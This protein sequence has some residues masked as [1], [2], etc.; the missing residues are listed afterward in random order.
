[1]SK[2]IINFHRSILD[3]NMA[4]Y[5]FCFNIYMFGF[6][7]VKDLNIFNKN[8]FKIFM[9][10]CETMAENDM[11]VSDIVF[12]KDV[13][14]KFSPYFL[15]TNIVNVVAGRY[16]GK[17]YSSLLDERGRQAD[18]NPFRNDTIV[19]LPTEAQLKQYMEDLGKV[20]TITYDFMQDSNTKATALYKYP[21][22]K[23]TRDKPLTFLENNNTTIH[24]IV[25]RSG[26]KVRGKR[27]Y[28]PI[29]AYID[30]AGFFESLEDTIN[31]L[32]GTL[33]SGSK[34][35]IT[36][37]PDNNPSGDYNS[38]FEREGVLHITAPSFLNENLSYRQFKA[39]TEYL[40]QK[41]IDIEFLGFPNRLTDPF[42][43]NRKDFTDLNIFNPDKKNIKT[44][45]AIDSYDRIYNSFIVCDFA[46]TDKKTSDYNVFT[47]I[48]VSY[49]EL[50][51]A[52]G[53]VIEV[54]PEFH[55]LDVETFKGSVQEKFEKALSNLYK[56][57]NH[58]LAPHRLC[59]DYDY[60]NELI[61]LKNS[62]GKS[63][64][65]P[66]LSAIYIPSNQQMAFTKVFIETMI[67]KI[68]RQ[69]D[70]DNCDKMA[71]EYRKDIGVRPVDTLNIAYIREIPNYVYKSITDLKLEQEEDTLRKYITVNGSKQDRA[72][73][74]ELYINENCYFSWIKEFDRDNDAMSERQLKDQL[75]SF[76]RDKNK[77][78]PHDDFID[79]FVTG[80]FIACTLHTQHFGGFDL[81]ENEIY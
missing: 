68:E 42:F 79:T 47:H 18:I 43:F 46:I 62:K 80:I 10:F 2:K 30:E 5:W 59:Y 72:G 64:R 56:R 3:Y 13:L 48:G 69:G 58:Y 24:L 45:Q 11:D 54:T 31:S 1:M 32:A 14:M 7:G 38:L 63:Y 33:I 12:T 67:N 25:A 28:S 16:S 9:K 78:I 74:V 29:G 23:N 70:I 21:F 55:V 35:Y 49:N 75:F 34:L 41:V 60:N 36:S 44:K 6:Y 77:K 27:T 76:S 8:T 15:Y 17:T 57:A 19:L 50:K 53:N 71:I 65:Y 81:D 73:N 52:D 39:R 20:F 37:S 61:E 22:T 4:G 51:D 40:P 26:D 66:T